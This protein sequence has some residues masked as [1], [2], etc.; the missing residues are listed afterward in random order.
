[1]SILAENIKYCR[2]RKGMTQ[3][4]LAKHRNKV[5]ESPF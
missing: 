4:E 2:E 1:M 3:E 5:L